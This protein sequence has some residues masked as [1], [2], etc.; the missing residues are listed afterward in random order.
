MVGS[1]DIRRRIPGV[2]ALDGVCG[3]QGRQ[4]PEALWTYV[5]VAG[6]RDGPVIQ[7]REP[8]CRL[9]LRPGSRSA[10]G[11]GAAAG[12]ARGIHACEGALWVALAAVA[13]LGGVLVLA[14]AGPSDAPGLLGWCDAGIRMATARPS[15]FSPRCGVGRGDGS[16]CPLEWP[17]ILANP[18]P[19]WWAVWFAAIL[20]MIALVA[21][22]VKIPSL[23]LLVAV[24][25]GYVFAVLVLAGVARAGAL[26]G[27][28]GLSVHLRSRV[29]LDSADGP[30]GLPRAEPG[31]K[32]VASRVV[33][34]SL[35]VVSALMSTV[36]PAR[37]WAAN[38]GRNTWPMPCRDSRIP[39]V[40]PLLIRACRSTS[41]H[42]GLMAPYAS[43]QVV[44]TPQ[45]GRR[46]SACD[47]DALRV[48][49]K[50]GRGGRTCWDGV[51]TWS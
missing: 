40:R 4:G 42:T 38:P 8:R 20:T 51:A 36:V 45:P 5:G 6:E 17:P 23:R 46:S 29:A 13:V 24:V 47:G 11:A 18:A 1:L 49:A 31:A 12:S 19:M 9:G 2:P 15:T 33:V 43:A 32:G 48:R 28:R 21:V 7:P 30:R 44:M 25:F 35:I 22:I 39:K 41:S 34:M 37:D 26:V 10:T 27:E 16:S 14:S 50:T 3:H